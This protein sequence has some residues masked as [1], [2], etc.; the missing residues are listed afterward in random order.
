M[1]RLL[2]WWRK[3]KCDNMLHDYPDAEGDW[4]NYPMHFYI[5][6]CRHCQKQFSI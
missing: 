6:T 4:A 5:Y 1:K 2:K 3:Y